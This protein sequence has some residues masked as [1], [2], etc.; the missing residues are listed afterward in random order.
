MALLLDGKQIAADLRAELRVVV[1]AIGAKGHRAP[2]LAVALVGDDPASAVYVRGKMKACAEIGIQSF[3]ERLGGNTT[4]DQLLA[5]IDQWNRDDRVDGILVQLPLP[6]QIDSAKIVARIAADKDVDGF[7]AQNLGLLAGGTPRLVACTPA[8]VMHMLARHTA[9]TGWEIKGKR[10]LV[11]GRSITVGRPMALLL[12]N[13]DATVTIAHSRT[14]DL[15]TAVQEAELLI[16]AAGQRHLIRGQ[17]VREG[18]VVIDVG[19]H[20]DEAG[21]LTGDVDFDAAKQR[22]SA[23]SPVPGGVGPMTIAMLMKN[24][25]DAF[26]GHIAADKAA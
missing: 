14:L 17:W 2:G 18:A 12:L 9:Q 19:I 11:V 25:V 15:Q 21:K 23:I 7:G 24:T 10:A 6:R 20:R 5:I 13:A 1:A 4:T 22:A 3:A 8:G 16:A 26:R